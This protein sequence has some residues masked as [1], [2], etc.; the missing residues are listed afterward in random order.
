M[1]Q[2]SPSATPPKNRWLS[3][4]WVLGIAAVIITC[5]VLQ[6][7]A[8]LYVLCTLGISILLGVVAKADLTESTQNRSEL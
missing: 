7:T 6:Q 5:L 2:N 1:V 3:L 8:L 4:A